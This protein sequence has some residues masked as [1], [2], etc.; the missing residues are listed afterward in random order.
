MVI[1]REMFAEANEGVELASIHLTLEALP[2][3]SSVTT[4]HKGLARQDS[5]NLPRCISANRFTELS[6]Q[7]I[8]QVAFLT[9]N[10]AI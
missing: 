3:D 9:S 7:V 4:G 1:D 2:G 10:M 5:R 8:C 6:L